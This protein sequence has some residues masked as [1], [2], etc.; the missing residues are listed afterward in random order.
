MCLLT[1]VV[2]EVTQLVV[3]TLTSTPP[4]T[5]RGLAFSQTTGSSGPQ[6]FLFTSLR[7]RAT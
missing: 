4:Y 7:R 2:V 1:G 3:E 6:L 5:N